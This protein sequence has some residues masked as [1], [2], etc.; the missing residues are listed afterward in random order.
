MKKSSTI[1]RILFNLHNYITVKLGVLGRF[2][3]RSS[4]HSKDL[5]VSAYLLI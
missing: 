3:M 1:T 4:M 5:E 2:P